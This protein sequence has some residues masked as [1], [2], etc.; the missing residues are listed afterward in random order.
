VRPPIAAIRSSAPHIS[1]IVFGAAAISAAF[2]TPSGVSQRATTLR[3]GIVASWPALSVFASMTLRYAVACRASRSA[4]CSG[5]ATEF[6]RT[7]TRSG[8]I[9]VATNASRAAA[10]PEAGTASSRSSTT[11]SAASTAF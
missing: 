2:S 5:L 11:T 4:A 3:S 10:L 8:S 6:T 7:M 1:A 9:G